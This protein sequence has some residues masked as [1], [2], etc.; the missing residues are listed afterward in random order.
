VKTSSEP[1]AVDVEE[2]TQKDEMNLRTPSSA[3]IDKDDTAASGNR[4]SKRAKKDDNGADSLLQAFDRGTQ[5]LTSAIRDAASKK[6]LPP[7]LFEAM[8]SL[9]GFELEQKAKYYSYLLNHP[10]VAHGFVDAPL[11][12][13]LS[14]ITEFINANM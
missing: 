2:D 4:P 13:K 8:D 12:Y 10:N 1:L 11:L 9:P 14:M 5:T 7:G 3:T 6:A